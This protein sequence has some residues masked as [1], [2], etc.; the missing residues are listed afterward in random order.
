[1]HHGQPTPHWM[2]KDRD[3]LQVWDCDQGRLHVRM[4]EDLAR[5]S[6]V[7]FDWAEYPVD[8]HFN[9]KQ[10]HFP[11]LSIFFKTAI[12]VRSCCGPKW[13]PKQVCH[14]TLDPDAT[15]RFEDEASSAEQEMRRTFGTDVDYPLGEH[16]FVHERLT[17]LGSFSLWLEETI[18]IRERPNTV[19]PAQRVHGF[20]EDSVQ[21]FCLRGGWS[22][23]NVG[24]QKS[25]HQLAHLEA[26]LVSEG[27]TGARSFVV[28]VGVEG[29]SASEL[30]A[31]TLEDMTIAEFKGM[32]N[33]GSICITEG[34][35]PLVKSVLNGFIGA[36][37]YSYYTYY[38][39]KC[40]EK[41]P[42]FSKKITINIFANKS[43]V[44]FITIS[45]C[46][47]SFIVSSCN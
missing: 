35:N 29:H 17:V 22:L 6:D 9:R 3:L 13:T 18:I 34:K 19:V 38:V 28:P 47:F 2:V 8:V 20:Q 33:S 36:S 10:Q 45:T 4:R 21:R 23:I 12:F 46:C 41:I 37:S 44:C 25:L 40:Y 15:A 30:K 32:A 24:G 7:H 43:Y 39:R 16:K 31:K 26:G 5:F 1:M 27:L 11:A 42:I 14:L